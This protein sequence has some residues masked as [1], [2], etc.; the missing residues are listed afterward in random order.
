MC[1][2]AREP[3]DPDVSLVPPRQRGAAGLGKKA[4]AYAAAAL[5]AASAT[6]PSCMLRMLFPA[7]LDATGARMLRVTAVQVSCWP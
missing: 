4:A 7:V 1:P 2:R 3:R 5:L 6:G